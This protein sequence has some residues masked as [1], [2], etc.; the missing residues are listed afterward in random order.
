MGEN[1][2][3]YLPD[4]GKFLQ[5]ISER[6]RKRAYDSNSWEYCGQCCIDTKAQDRQHIPFVEILKKLRGLNIACL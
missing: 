4:S 6:A 5:K 1:D 3:I 2:K